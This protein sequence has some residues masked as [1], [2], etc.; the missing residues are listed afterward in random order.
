MS[1]IQIPFFCLN[2]NCK[3]PLTDFEIKR[4]NPKRISRYWFCLECRRAL[5]KSHLFVKCPECDSIFE[6]HN[7]AKY[8]G[9]C[10][11]RSRGVY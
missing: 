1:T 6:Q 8:C 2:E 3:K 7:L 5:Q 11:N 9:K 10:C 4:R